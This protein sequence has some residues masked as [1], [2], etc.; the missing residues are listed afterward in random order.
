MI[1]NL[2]ISALTALIV[3]TAGIALTQKEPAA[4]QTVGSVSSPDISSPYFSYGGVRFDAGHTDNLIQASTTGAICTFQTAPATT[5]LQEGSGVRLVVSTTTAST[6]RVYTDS[7]QGGT[8]TFLF[9]ASVA[10]N[11]QATVVATTTNNSFVIGPSQ[12]INVIMTGGTGTFS[13]TGTCGY[14]ESEL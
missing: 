11:A 13:P 7:I 4:P 12:W 2:V 8:T 1:K 9:G 3:V 10:A 6:V 5:T 14:S